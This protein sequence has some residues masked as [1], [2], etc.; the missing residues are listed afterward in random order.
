MEVPLQ[1]YVLGLFRDWYR[2]PLPNSPLSTSKVC[3]CVRVWVSEVS[4]TTS[5]SQGLQEAINSDSG[6]V[7]TPSGP[8]L[9]DQLRHKSFG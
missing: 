5:D 2:D 1:G 6:K 7:W 8:N 4:N 9:E 3:K